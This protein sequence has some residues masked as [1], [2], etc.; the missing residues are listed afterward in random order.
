LKTGRG[1]RNPTK[2]ELEIAL[3]ASESVA[4]TLKAFNAS[5]AKSIAETVEQF[6]RT[7]GGD[8]IARMI[9]AFT[10]QVAPIQ[11]VLAS[12]DWSRL[13]AAQSGISQITA[14]FEKSLRPVLD[15]IASVGQ[16]I[17][18]A[19]PTDEEFERVSSTL[20]DRGWFLG[21]VF[22]IGIVRQVDALL[23]AGDDEGVEA[24]MEDYVRDRVEGI[25][26]AAVERCA[27]RG[28]ILNSAM[29]AHAEGRFELSVPVLLAQADGMAGEILGGHLF[30]RDN[31]KTVAS[32]KMDSKLIEMGITLDHGLLTVALAPVYD[33]ASIGIHTEDR[34]KKREQDP[35][36][37]PLNRHGVLHGLD[38]DYGTEGNSLR[39]LLLLEFLLSVETVF[40]T[41]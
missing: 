33:A 24:L 19:F 37:G 30:R 12:V 27:S 23:A 40:D 11:N 8:A 35:R 22:P 13:V 3:R 32:R 25:V 41:D 20:A 7:M 16:V 29:A 26:A 17:A 39:A 2:A 34:D 1:D 28:E 38:V 15:Q 9:N 10:T 14:N 18:S 21:L 31:K 5:Y 4:Q 36:Y 6:Q